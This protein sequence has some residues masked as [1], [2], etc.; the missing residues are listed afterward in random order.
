MLAYCLYTL[1][2]LWPV[3]PIQNSGLSI[4]PPVGSMPTLLSAFILLQANY[5]NLF[6]FQ[7]DLGNYVRVLRR[8]Q[9]D[10][11]G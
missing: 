4:R 2:Y 7:S 11:R 1:D 8:I 10:L 3:S 6:E 9:N 5:Y